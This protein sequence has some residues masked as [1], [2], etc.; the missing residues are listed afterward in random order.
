[1][2]ANQ[3]RARDAIVVSHPLQPFDARN[4]ERDV[5]VPGM[6]WSFD[7]LHLAGARAALNQRRAAPVF[8]ERGL[9]LDESG[10]IGLDEL[11][12]FLRH[13][14]RAFLR[15]RLHVSLREKT[16]DFEDAIPINL[17]GLEEWKIADRVLQAR[18]AGASLEACVD[19]ERARGA[20]PP[21]RLADPVLD[22]IAVQVE[23]L[24][25]VGQSAL[26]PTSLDVHVDL[27]ATLGIVGTVAGVRGD[28][29]HSVTYSKLG[30]AVRLAAWA[31]L[32][33]LTATWPDRPFEALT[34]GR[35][36]SNRG[37]VSVAR[38]PVLG[39]D[40]VSRRAEAERQL[41]TL[42][43]LFRRGMCEPLP[44]YCRT[45]A[46]W[47]EAISGGKDETSAADAAARSWMSDFTFEKEDREP[48]HVLVLG[49]ALPFVAMVERAGAP[50]A[51][52]TEWDHGAESRFALYARRLWDGLLM[53]EQLVDR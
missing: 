44:L 3:G 26:P 13:P 43:D 28:V 51:D 46:A 42:A 40:E 24:V 9:A 14:V 25:A 16:R 22:R 52:E 50:R 39:P 4:F 53:H 45:S 38:I 5:L 1:M 48:E 27:S 47:A 8:L 37:T 19:A 6:P 17:D 20:L 49:E 21:G 30:P 33:V 18:L 34:V 36:R 12:R 23:E 2:C 41:C 10:P 11:E 29:V 7:A 31:R 15:E 32:L 35:A